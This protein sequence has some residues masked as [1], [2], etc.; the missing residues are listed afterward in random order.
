MSIVVIGHRGTARVVGFVRAAEEAGLR[1]DVFSH[2]ELIVSPERLL[3]VDDEACFV[4]IETLGQSGP[5]GEAKRAAAATER[6]LLALGEADAIEDRR[7][8]VVT[9]AH[10]RALHGE[11][12]APRQA[13][14]GFLRYLDDLAH[15]ARPSWRFLSSPASIRTMFDKDA[16][17]RLLSSRGVPV[18]D[19][20]P[21][22]GTPESVLD[23]TKEGPCFV[24]LGCGSSAVGVAYL[25]A[26]RTGRRVLFSTVALD[27]EAIRSSRQ[28]RRYDR[29][30]SIDAVLAFLLGEGARV[31]RA[32]PKLRF[33]G[34]AFDLRV[35]T[36]AGHPARRLART[37]TH[38]I[39]NVHAGGKRV[40]LPDIRGVLVDAQL[41]AAME[42]VRRAA[43]A[44]DALQ[45]GFDVAFDARHGG[46]VVLEANA[47]GDFFT[48]D[49]A[50]YRAQVEALAEVTGGRVSGASTSAR[51][52]STVPS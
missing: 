32:V 29:A 45:V 3:D 40:P 51:G 46:H 47:F 48:G 15:V 49:D 10:R 21:H 19:A 37:S 17:A 11:L 30:E 13:H 18:P 34:R 7:C 2:E 14:F 4:R 22:D 6:L 28:V 31:E 27:G 43:A 36:I 16:T 33:R 35:V 26:L 25:L 42:S 24:K 38:V 9:D 52:D 41:E 5:G 39:T 1:V 44:F 8:R 20:V 50:I 23:A 12:I